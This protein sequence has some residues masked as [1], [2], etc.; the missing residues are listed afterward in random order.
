MAPYVVGRCQSPAH[1]LS[2]E[3]HTAHIQP[4]SDL[5]T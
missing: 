1:Q 2:H 4:P 3:K 5:S